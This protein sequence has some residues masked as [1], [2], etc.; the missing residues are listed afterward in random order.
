[1]GAQGLRD[2]DDG[3]EKIEDDAILAQVQKQVRKVYIESIT[4]AALLTVIFAVV[5]T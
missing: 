1:M 3:P 4:S 5:P 2:M